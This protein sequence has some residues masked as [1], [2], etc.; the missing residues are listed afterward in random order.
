MSQNGNDRGVWSFFSPGPALLLI[1]GRD[2]L[3]RA[4]A[5]SLKA[6]T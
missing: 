2:D 6:S 1:L 3:L 4:E 5:S